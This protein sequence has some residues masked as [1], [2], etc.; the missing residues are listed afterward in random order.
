MKE[1]RTAAW[2]QSRK[3]ESQLPIYD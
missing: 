2:D 3:R 1:P